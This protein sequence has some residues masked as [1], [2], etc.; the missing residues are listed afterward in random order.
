[1]KEKKYQI[2]VTESQLRLIANCVEDCHRFMGGQM[3]MQNSTS[4]LDNFHLIGDKLQEVHSLVVPELH[5][6]HGIQGSYGWNGGDCPNKY[7]RRFLAETYYL[8]REIKHFL[9]KGLA[10]WCVYHSPTLRC[11]ESGEVITIKELKDENS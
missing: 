6:H 3:E 9:S 5:K 11:E 7:Q 1:M 2:T 10:G 8:Y 4:M